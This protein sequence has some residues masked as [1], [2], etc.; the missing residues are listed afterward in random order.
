MKCV[1]A[2]ERQVLNVPNGQRAA[3]SLYSSALCV[4]NHH[5]YR[6]IHEFSALVLVTVALCRADPS[7]LGDSSLILLGTKS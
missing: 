2:T 1:S 7:W 3:I 6:I 4:L 5:L